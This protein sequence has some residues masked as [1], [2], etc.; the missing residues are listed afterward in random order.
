MLSVVAEPLASPEPVWAG[1]NPRSEETRGGF[2]AHTVPEYLPRSATF[3]FTLLRRQRRFRPV[4]LARNTS[5]LA[6]FPLEHVLAVEDG[7]GR[8]QHLERRIRARF[9]GFPERY[10]RLIAEEARRHGCLLLHAHFGWSGPPS[11]RASRSLDVP[12]VTTFYGR[13]LSESHRTRRRDPYAS[14]F[15]EGSLFMCEGPAMAAHLE[16]IGGPSARIRVVPIGIEL[17]RFPFSMRPRERPLILIQCARLV[18]KKGVDLTIRAFAAARPRLGESE[19][20]IVGDGPLRSDLERLAAHLGVEASVRFHGLVSHD[21]YRHLAEAAHMC[22]QPSRTASDGDTE[23][24]APVVLLEMQALGVPVVA[25]RHADIPAVVSRPAELVEEE[26]VDGLAERIIALASLDERDF[27]ARATEARALVELRHGAET[28][29]EAV[30]AVYDE[31]L[32]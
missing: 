14:L 17:E 6:E 25:T 11:L 21:V 31:A 32:T 29:A 10:E 13:D 24:G 28:W 9:R 20:W 1:S 27:A 12:L 4:V 3:I 8:L 7:F 16:R 30:D 26:D 15:A 2:V 23:G 19:L 18:E 5:N 22:V